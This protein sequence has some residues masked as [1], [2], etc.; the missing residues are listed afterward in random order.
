MDTRTATL[1]I[2]SQLAHINGGAS[3]WNADYVFSWSPT[4]REGFWYIDEI[5]EF[6][7]ITVCQQEE[8]IV[9]SLSSERRSRVTYD[10]RGYTYDEEVELAGELL[11]D[12]IEHAL[13]HIRKTD[14]RFDD[15]FIEKIET[16]FGLL[17]PTGVVKMKVVAVFL[18]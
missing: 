17:K 2:I 11:A 16:D 9:H 10:I 1:S 5:N 7:T 15:V 18:R 13:M 6:P 4:V 3:P 8:Q 12:D 14:N